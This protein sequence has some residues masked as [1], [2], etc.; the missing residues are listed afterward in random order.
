[1]KRNYPWP[2][3]AFAMGGLAIIVAMSLVQGVGN[4]ADNIDPQ[5]D[6][7]Q[8]AY[9]ENVGWLNAE[10]EGDG[11]SGILVEIDGLSGYLYGENVGWISLSCLNDASCDPNYGV[12]NDGT[13]IL[14]GWSHMPSEH[15]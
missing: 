13:G 12:T 2:K 1:M 6:G 10:P 11:G 7:S 5:D 8:F 14:A 15:F 9:G 3:I 4:A